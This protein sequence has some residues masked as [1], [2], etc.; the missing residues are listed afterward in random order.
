MVRVFHNSKAFDEDARLQFGYFSKPKEFA[1]IIGN[2]PTTDFVEVA[3]VETDN[4]H[5]AYE[6]T[7]S[8]EAAWYY[9]DGLT[10]SFDLKE[11]VP[12]NEECNRKRSTS[13]A[14]I[15]ELNGQFFAVA[16]CGFVEIR[17]RMI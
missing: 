8:I 16:T 7:N 4:L 3:K 15:M 13:V 11:Q 6:Q 12:E 5:V 1:E 17:K 14:D 2:Q 9:N 10:V